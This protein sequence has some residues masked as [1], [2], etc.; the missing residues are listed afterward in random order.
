VRT[1]LTVAAGTLSAAAWGL[2]AYA[3]RQSNPPS[4]VFFLAV[5][6]VV[7]AAGFGVFW[8]FAKQE[9]PPAALTAVIGFGLLF[10][11]IGFLGQPLYEDD[12]YRYLWDGRSIALTGNPYQHPP[13]DSF[14]QTELPPKFDEILSRINY[15]EIPTIYG[16]V[17]QLAFLLSYWIS[18]GDLWPLKLIFLAADLGTLVLLF[19][20]LGPSPALVIYAWSPLVIKEIAFTA[21][22]DALAAAFVMAGVLLAHRKRDMAAATALGLA[23]AARSFTIILVPL[24]LWERWRAL[25][26]SILVAAALYAPFVVTGAS[27]GGSMKTFATQWEFNSFAYGMLKNFIGP[28]PALIACFVLFGAFYVWFLKNS[29][30]YSLL[31]GVFFLLSPVVNAWYLVL[32]VPFVAIRPSAWGMAAVTVVLVSYATGANLRLANFGGYDHPWWV[33]AVEIIPILMALAWDK[34][35]WRRTALTSEV[36]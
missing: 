6:A 1:G 20:L 14:G 23:V 24:L 7:S 35:I 34:R 32:L 19:R 33:R 16:P 2:L 3:S 36:R 26:V 21:H 10:R 12:F 15:P 30:D 5:L 29:D 17:C 8:I 18:P 13:A 27:G 4:I 11:L 25:A 31:L 28:A 22:T 9:L